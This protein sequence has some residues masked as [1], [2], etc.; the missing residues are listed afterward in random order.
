MR[1]A[2]RLFPHEA[3][4]AA[5]DRYRCSECAVCFDMEQT[6]V[7]PRCCPACGV[8]YEV[9]RE[10]QVEQLARLALA[11][12]MDPTTLL[13]VLRVTIAGFQVPR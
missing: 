7:G 9:S 11:L 10:L 8:I 4:T 6:V 12:N 2:I 3:T 5:K 13:W 1:Q